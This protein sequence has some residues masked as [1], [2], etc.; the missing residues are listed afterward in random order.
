LAGALFALQTEIP[1]PKHLYTEVLWATAG[2]GAYRLTENLVTGKISVSA[3]RAESRSDLLHSFISFVKLFPRGKQ[4]IAGIEE[5]FLRQVLGD[6]ADAPAAV[7]EDQHLASSGQLYSLIQG[8]E[9]LVVDIRPGLNRIWRQRGEPTVLCAHPY[10]LATWL[11]A[12]E[13]GAVISRPSGEPFDGE[14][15]ATAEI[16]WVG[17]ANKTLAGRYWSELHQTLRRHGIL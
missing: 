17:F 5:D 14:V 8:K 10:D 3:L 11:I 1:L 15:N 7:F 6:D 12:H 13:A 2:R 9:T 4:L 16:G